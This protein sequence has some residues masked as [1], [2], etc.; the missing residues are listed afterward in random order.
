[1]KKDR[2]LAAGDGDTPISPDE[3]DGLIPT[4]ITTRGELNEAEQ[5]NIVKA[6]SRRAPTLSTLL[7]HV[8]LRRLHRGMFSD[9]WQ[10]AGRE[11]TLETTP[12]V[13]PG[14][15]GTS[16]RELVADA[17]VWVAGDE[18]PDRVAARF[19]HR[20]VWIHAFPNGNGRHAREATNLLLMAQGLE[21]F[22]WGAGLDV[23]TD[24]LRQL[25]LS[26]LR[27]VDADREDLD[28]LQAFARR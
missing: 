26:A 28:D 12:G 9:V 8:Y 19:H 6:M 23:L 5:A 1:M 11:R 10:W 21:P 13:D 27:R 3:M 22:S 7:D 14:L 16:L 18:D 24:E 15:I 25:Y 2:L 4:Y 17:A 20:L